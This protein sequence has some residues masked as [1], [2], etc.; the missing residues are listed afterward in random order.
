MKF[1]LPRHHALALSSA[2]ALTLLSAC[3]GGGG[4]SGSP[5]TPAPVPPFG[6]ES[7]RAALVAG[8]SCS[9]PAQTGWC[10]AEL[11]GSSA[12][13]ARLIGLW[14]SEPGHAQAIA[15]DGVLFDSQ[16]GGR[17]WAARASGLTAIR[18]LSL[19]D[20]GIGWLS[21][22]R[23]LLRTS[24][25]GRNWLQ[26]GTLPAA[27]LERLE[28][29]AGATLRASASNS[30]CPIAGRCGLRILLSDNGGQ[31]WS[32]SG[33]VQP[34]GQ[35]V[36]LTPDVALRSEDQPGG[37][38]I[39]RSSD[40]G[41]SWQTLATIPPSSGWRFR[42]VDHQ[43]A[44]ILGQDSLLLR[45]RDGGASWDRLALPGGGGHG[46]LDLDFADAQHGWLVG[47]AGL[48]FATR[49]GGASWERQA[50]DTQQPLRFVKA[51]DAKTVWIAGDQQF[52][53][54]TASGGRTTP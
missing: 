24:D 16:D 22:G 31:S 15:S 46:L 43:N 5:V 30:P 2:L 25:R 38:L 40:A 33:T 47:H 49:D 45:T 44:W 36:F 9:G 42:R 52:V 6:V 37:T 17:R 41:R 51:L 32:A 21:D 12:G 34:Y 20:D 54:V 18:G 35:L 13:E 4:A 26:T 7:G 19:Q 48:V 11:F 29:T 8:L 50:L 3:G 14:A 10:K 53:W 28:I 23:V 39:Q 27:G 1:H